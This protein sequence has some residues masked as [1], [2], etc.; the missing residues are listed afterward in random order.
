M[1]P[2]TP[3]KDEE[4]LSGA[5]KE[6]ESRL[7]SLQVKIQSSQLSELIDRDRHCVLREVAFLL[8]GCNH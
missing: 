6:P 3:P 5:V 1:V 4:G 2:N 8:R 7:H